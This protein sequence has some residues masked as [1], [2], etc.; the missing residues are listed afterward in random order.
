MKEKRFL[1]KE[2]GNQLDRLRSIL[3]AL[4]SFAV[5]LRKTWIHTSP[6]TDFSGLALADEGIET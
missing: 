6:W 5:R 4:N 2:Q 3:V 1:N